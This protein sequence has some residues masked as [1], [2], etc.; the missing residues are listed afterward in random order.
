MLAVRCQR[1]AVSDQPSVITVSGLGA[2]GVALT[3]RFVL[4]E[5]WQLGGDRSGNVKTRWNKHIVFTR[6][7]LLGKGSFIDIGSEL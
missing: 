3:E 7:P 4:M 2:V 1:S 5:A 6:C